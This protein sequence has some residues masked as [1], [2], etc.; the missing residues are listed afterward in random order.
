M[1][2]FFIYMY[3]PEWHRIVAYILLLGVGDTMIWILDCNSS[4]TCITTHNIMTFSNAHELSVLLTQI[5][6]TSKDT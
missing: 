2:A 3:D 4:A 5:L 6:P 1:F